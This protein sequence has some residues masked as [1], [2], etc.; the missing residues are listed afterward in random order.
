MIYYFVKQ[1]EEKEEEDIGK[2]GSFTYLTLSGLRETSLEELLHLSWSDSNAYLIFVL[3]HKEKN[4]KQLK[5]KK[6]V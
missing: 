4:K 6:K 3:I 2:S 1:E 5:K